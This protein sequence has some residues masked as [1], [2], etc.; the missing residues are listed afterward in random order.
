MEVMIRK[1]ETIAT[2]LALGLFSSGPAQAQFERAPD[3]PTEE[4]PAEHS[5]VTPPRLK[6]FE[7]AAYP[8]E[9]EK[10]GLVAEVVLRLTIDELGSVRDVDVV[11]PVGNGFDEAASLAATKFTF[12]PAMRHG[13]AV[14]SKI[15]YRYS[16]TLTPVEVVQSSSVSPPRVGDL[17]AVLR[18]AGTEAPLVGAEIV[19]VSPQ[20]QEL[21]QQ[22]DAQGRFSLVG[23]APGVYRVRLSSPG[24]ISVEAS[25]SV[26]VGKATEVVYR[27]AIET[28]EGAIE[29]T[30]KGER[31]QREVT[32]RTIDRREIE[33]IPGSSGDAIRSIE[34]LPGVARPPVFAGILVV[35][36]SYPQDTQ[37]FVDGSGIPLVYHF[38]GLR[39]VLPTELIERIDFYPGNYGVK[40][41]RGMGGIVDVGLKSPETRCKDERGNFTEKRGCLSGLAQVDLIEG[42]LLLQGSTPV[43]GW[44]FAIAARRSW[45]DAWIKPLL[46]EAGATTKSLPVYYDYQAIVERK[47]SSDS[48][49]SLRF[50][51][52]DDRFAAVIDPLA[53]EPAFGGNLQFGTAFMQAQLLDERAIGSYVT[54]ATLATLGK[55]SVGLG[56]G[57]YRFNMISHPVHWREELGFK[58]FKGVRLNTGLDFLVFPYEISVRAPAPPIPGQ[59]KAG[60]FSTE[61]VIEASEAVTG[62]RQGWYADAELQPTN[63][64]RIVPGLR[65]DYARDSRQ[66]DF[67][68]RLNARY[69]LVSGRIDADGTMHR[70]TT[71]KA[72]IGH[73]YQPPQFQESNAIYGTLGLRSNRALHFALG[74]E[75]E[76]SKQLDISLEGFYK[77]FEHLV[78]AAGVLDPVRYTNNG[79]GKSYGLETLIRYKPDEHFF[80]WLAYTLSRSERQDSPGDA[81]YLI[82]Y[83][84]THNLTVLGSYRLGDGWE[85]GARFRAISGSLVTPARS[86]PSLP[87]IYAADSGSYV[88]LQGQPYSERLPLFHQLDLRLDKRWQTKDYRFSTYLDVYNVYNNA[89]TEAIA[90][91][92]NFAHRIHQTGIPILPS[93]GVRGEF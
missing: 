76:L 17:T 10:L 68:P 78:A 4:V 14:K 85:F 6:H 63:R 88:P 1:R 64:L 24:F 50:F 56:V 70:R 31:P 29:V 83:D 7:P 49:T 16:F 43:K 18:I 71:A 92:Y 15:L 67:S 11:E 25:E 66:V 45:L 72:G 47:L 55:T 93:L 91:D 26:V 42:R 77:N 69:D 40:Y 58:L 12:E 3:P 54:L 39:S 20:G 30:V 84:Q 89:A 37:V 79:L 86:V 52:S 60:P 73:Y 75:Q 65:V 21:R 80:G 59:P 23:V 48:R 2:L 19:I 62:L 46:E 57:S 38:G 51:G 81:P 36:G 34:S 44:S 27:V 28:K 53:Q 82:P 9:A 90:Y 74:L 87:G 33:R 41:G 61:P 22:S 32:R 13:V 8:S 5:K 35:R